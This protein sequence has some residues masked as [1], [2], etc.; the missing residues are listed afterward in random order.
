LQKFGEVGTGV[1]YMAEQE[2][3]AD[4]LRRAVDQ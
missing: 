4:Q 2:H 3:P 1:V